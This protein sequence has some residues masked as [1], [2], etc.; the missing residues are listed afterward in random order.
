MADVTEP[1]RSMV[2]TKPNINRGH[3]CKNGDAH[4]LQ[5]LY[6]KDMP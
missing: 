3:H 2:T 1:F 5:Q 4:F 6:L